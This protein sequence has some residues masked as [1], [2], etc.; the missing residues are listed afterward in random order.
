MEGKVGDTTILTV[1]ITDQ[2]DY[3]V[4]VSGPIDHPIPGVEDIII[5]TVPVIVSDGQTTTLQVILED[6][7]PIFTA[8]VTQH[9]VDEEGLA[10]ASTQND[11]YAGDLP[12]IVLT[13]SDSLNIAWGA[14]NADNDA[15]IGATGDRTV[16]FNATQPFDS[17]NLTSNGLAV[18]F[19]LLSNGTTLVGY[20][21]AV[22]P[23]ATNSAGVVF[24]A[25]LNDDNAG[26]YNFTLVDN[27]D[28]PTA[29]TEDDLNLVFGFTAKDSDGDT[30]S[31]TFSVVAD[32]D[33]PVLTAP[34]TQHFVDEEGL[35]SASTQNDPYA[36]DLPGIVLTASDSLNIA[37]GADNADNDALIGATGDRTVTFNATQPFDSLNFTS[38]GLAVHFVLLSNGTTLVGYTGAVVPTATNSAGV[39]FYATLN[40][41][42]AGSYNFT[43]VDNLDHP[44]ANTEDDLNLVFGFT[45]KDSDGDTVSGTF[46]VVADDDAPVLTAPVT[47]HFVDEEGLASASTQNDPYAGDLP[48][49]VLTAS[50]SLNIAWGADNADN[51]ALIGATGDR[52]VT[53]NA[54]Q[55]FDSLNL[56]SNGLAVHFVLLSNGTTLVGYTGAVVPTATNSAGVVFYATLNDDNA[57]SYNFTLVD[58]LDHPTANTEDDLN[59]VF[60]FTAKDSDGDTVSGTFSVV[61]DDDAPVLTAPVTQ[62][63][64]DEEGLASASTQNDPYAGDLP[65]IVLTASDSLNIAWG[66]DNADNDALI[67]ATGDRTVTFNATQPFDSLNLTS[68]G[69]AV[70]FV[71]LSNG[72][73]LVGYTGAVV[74][75]ATNSAGVVFYATLNDDNAGSYNFTLVDNLDH[76]TANTEDDLN[77]VFGFT[78]KDSDG[79]TVSGTFSVVADDD[80]PVL[81]APVTQHFVDEEGLASASTQ[82]D[83]YAGDLPGIV[84]TASDSLNIA[85]GAD[86]ADNDALIGATGDRTVTFNATQPFDSLNLHL[87]RAGGALCAAQQ[88]H[89]AGWLYRRG[90]SDRDEL[91]R[92]GVLRHPQRRQRRQL[93]LHAGRQSR[94]S[95]RQH[96]RRSQS[97]L[98]LHRQGFRRRHRERNLLGGR[99]RRR[100]GPHRAGDTALCRR[101]RPGERINAER[102]LCGRSARHRAHRERQ[103]QHCLGR[104]QCRQRR[105]HR[106]HRRPHRHLQRHP[107]L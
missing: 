92:R 60:G 5:V 6:D 85:W 54:T 4:T 2:G 71:L 56:T 23:T 42:N 36:G 76:P 39:V 93:Q 45:A 77:L 90:C 69:L 99:R 84:L 98:R 68:N 16:T 106:R 70:H 62:H 72:T 12:G 11:P 96:R 33:A 87:Q 83:P 53:F 74:P 94:P 104:R 50:D 25:T 59:L 63:F 41:D 80:A 73:T 97:R 31:G 30:V 81:T 27:L 82:N 47:Q 40:D 91:G 86:N 101:G 79:D 24:Y 9:F 26:S 22:V 52:T 18:H 15:L 51:D 66:A 32:D 34:V 28:H 58:N 100:P 35:A 14:D 49:I 44:T 67:G 38:N 57:G 102:P 65:G 64:V 3:T 88:R 75:T 7:S 89:D 55:P 46:S 107:A 13:A 95:D 78:A 103:P 21:G 1:T 17:L 8:P 10:S 43:L 37:W 20:T 61:A 19:V 105:P 29:N 48:G